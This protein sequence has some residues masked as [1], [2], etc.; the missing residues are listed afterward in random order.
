MSAMARNS[1][2]LY[3]YLLNQIDRREERNPYNVDEV[4]V[5][6]NNDCGRGLLMCE[7][8]S[9]SNAYQNNKESNQAT[10]YV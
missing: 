9:F 8:T 5:I 4:P 6:R 1:L 3:P 7:A 10:R 2:H